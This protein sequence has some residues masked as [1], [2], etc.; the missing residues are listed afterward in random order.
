MVKPHG[1]DTAPKR[2]EGHH[3]GQT[4]HPGRAGRGRGPTYCTRCGQSSHTAPFPPGHRSGCTPGRQGTCTPA[5]QHTH[6][7]SSH[8]GPRKARDPPE[9]GSGQTLRCSSEAGTAP[10]GPAGRGTASAVCSLSVAL[11]LSPARET[12]AAPSASGTGWHQADAC[13]QC[14]SP[15]TKKKMLDP[16]NVK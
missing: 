8:T 14:N 13:V 2:P 9:G 4:V 1:C 3:P 10:T 11:R 6:T 5:P 16:C 7:K 12:K 15:S